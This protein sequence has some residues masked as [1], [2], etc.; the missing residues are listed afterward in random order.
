MESPSD[1]SSNFMRYRNLRLNYY[2]V[3]ALLARSSLYFG[4]KESAYR[5][6]MEVIEASEDGIFPFVDKALVTGSP[7]DPDRI[8]SSEVIFALSHSQRNTLFKDYYDPS[9]I[10]NYVFR[11]DNDLMNDAVFG[12]GAATGGNQ[13]DYRY[14]VNWTATGNNRYFYKYSD[15]SDYGNIRN[16]MIPMI[17]LGEMYLVAAESVS[18]DL[19]A[20]TP[21]VNLLRANRGVNGIQELTPEILQYEH[22][23]ELYGEGQLF[24]MYKRLYAP[25][26][27]SSKA[28]MNPQPSDRIFTVPLPDSETEN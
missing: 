10:P 6:A 17:R 5:Y 2:A 19:A 16:T 24:F 1:G 20:G 4:D 14:R 8:F 9:R 3:S 26:L 22:I 13:D 15:M 11:M 27:F 25:V 18:E 23:R 28:S 12:G 7:D 21:F